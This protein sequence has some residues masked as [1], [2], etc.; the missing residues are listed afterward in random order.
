MTFGDGPHRCPG[1]QVALHETRTFLDALFRV[2]GIRMTRP[3]TP[4]WTGTTYELH[5]AIIECDRA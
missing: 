3:P 1:G 4:S 2:P 5:G